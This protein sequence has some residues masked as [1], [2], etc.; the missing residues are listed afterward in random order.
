M[1]DAKIVPIIKLCG[2]PD[3]LF[4]AIK[5]FPVRTQSL[6]NI[7]ID[8]WWTI[9]NET[10]TFEHN[11]SNLVQKVVQEKEDKDEEDH[12]CLVCLREVEWIVTCV[13]YIVS[14]RIDN[15]CFIEKDLAIT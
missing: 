6:I 3:F 14:V 8:F 15:W 11:K 5:T 7:S 9:S 1:L 12:L 2:V 10:D 13:F 4:D